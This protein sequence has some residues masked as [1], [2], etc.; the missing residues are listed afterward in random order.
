MLIVRL[1]LIV[2]LA[3]SATGFATTPE[4]PDGCYKSFMDNGGCPIV[5]GGGNPDSYIPQGCDDGCDE[6]GAVA[7]CC[8]NGYYSDSRPIPQ[9]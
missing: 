7:Y 5:Q 8:E 3:K 4:C 1:L 2:C 6:Y 9:L